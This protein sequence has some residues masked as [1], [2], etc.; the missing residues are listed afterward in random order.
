MTIHHDPACFTRSPED[1]RMLPERAPLLTPSVANSLAVR[2]G[3]DRSP[4]AAECRGSGTDLHLG[5]VCRRGVQV[6]VS[7]CDAEV[8][9][10]VAVAGAT[11]AH[12]MRTRQTSAE[13]TGPSSSTVM[14][15]ARRVGERSALI[16]IGSRYRRCPFNFE[17]DALAGA[18]TGEWGNECRPRSRSLSIPGLFDLSGTWCKTAST[19]C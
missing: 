3:R 5:R 16:G 11:L 10:G 18:A 6:P 2:G 14:V 15:R 4:G 17:A 1:W 9:S 8:E 12:G 7:K 13:A 19:E